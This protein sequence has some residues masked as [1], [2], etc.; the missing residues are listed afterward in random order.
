MYG[1]PREVAEDKDHIEILEAELY[2]LQVTHFDFLQRDD[3]ERCIRQVDK[4][5]GCRLEKHVASERY[6]RKC[7]FSEGNVYLELAIGVVLCC[8]RDLGSE[9]LELLVEL[10]ALAA[11]LLF[12]F[13]LILVPVSRLSLSITRL[14]ECSICHFTDE[15]HILSWP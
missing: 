6:T 2:S 3:Q 8:V 1:R 4:A 13:D 11:F 14:V 5:L 12:L 9:S 10:L 15:L 7:E